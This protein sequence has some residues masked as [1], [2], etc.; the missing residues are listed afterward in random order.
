MPAEPPPP[1]LRVY[2]CYIDGVLHTQPFPHG[3]VETADRELELNRRFHEW[4]EMTAPGAHG[5]GRV[6]GIRFADMT[7]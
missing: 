1:P 5:E 4:L 2:S 6:K 7:E 3:E